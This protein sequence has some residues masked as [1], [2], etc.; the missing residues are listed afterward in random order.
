MAHAYWP[1]FNLAVH[2]P[3]VELRYPDDDLLTELAS[4]AAKGVH[5]PATMPFSQPWTD[6][7]PGEL[8]R[9]TLHYHWRSRAEWTPAAWTCEFVVLMDGVVV[10]AQALSAK[11]FRELR[12][13]ET[14]S[15][16]GREHQGRGIGKEMRAAVLHFGFAGLEAVCATT[17]AFDDNAASLAVTRALGYRDNGVTYEVR[18]GERARQ[19]R[20]MMD[21]D[22][23]DSRRRDDIDI[24]GLDACIDLFVGSAT[25]A[26]QDV[27]VT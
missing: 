12:C 13:F 18:R 3:R 6:Q 1:L 15:W 19:L 20:F 21:R 23:W 10:G 26:D 8:E 17:S 24:V 11:D 4:V 7:P 14:G 27:S 9:G 16:L 22:Q 25:A 5:D 2:T